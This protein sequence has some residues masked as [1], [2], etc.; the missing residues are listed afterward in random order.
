[1]SQVVDI[2]IVNN[3]NKKMRRPLRG[4]QENQC[5]LPP[6]TLAEGKTRNSLT[7]PEPP[8]SYYLL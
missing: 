6:S 7:E 1:M 4:S 3:Y 5:L 8:A 2:F